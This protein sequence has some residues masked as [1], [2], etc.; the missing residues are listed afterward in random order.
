[1]PNWSFN[2]YKCVG[3]IKEILDLNNK[4]MELDNMKE[5]LEPNGFGNLWL[6]CLVKILDGDIEKIYCRGDITEFS[7]NEE[8]NV[9]TIDTQTAWAEMDEVRHFIEKVYPGL[10]IYY[11]EE[12]PGM[13]IYQTNDKHGH[14]FPQR[15]ILDDLDG[16]GSE[17][18]DDIDSLLKSASEIFD[19]ELKTMA[20]LEE[21]VE[22][23]D[24][25]S[26]HC[27]NV[28]ND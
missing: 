16:E 25:F 9:L 10:K 11:Y 18:Y 12:E 13:E 17:Y 27:V 28:V 23:S 24:C 21:I 15:Y 5:P 6:G 20:D 7:Y 4:L 14:F 8:N 1:M 26:L 3:D 19:K 22:E 2:T